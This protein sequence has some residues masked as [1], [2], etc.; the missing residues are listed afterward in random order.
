MAAKKKTELKKTV[1]PK[2][3]AGKRVPSPKAGSKK[4]HLSPERSNFVASK[5]NCA[6]RSC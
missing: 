6:N 2:V 1:K 3:R 4:H 5:T